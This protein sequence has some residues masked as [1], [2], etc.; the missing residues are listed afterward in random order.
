ME[1][2]SGTVWEGYLLETSRPGPR[3]FLSSYLSSSFCPSMEMCW[4]ELQKSRG[5]RGDLRMETIHQDGEAEGRSLIISQSP[6]TT[7]SRLL[8]PKQEYFLILFIIFPNIYS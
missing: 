3:S 8:L 1:L 4:L 6:G 2:F 5:P 7:I